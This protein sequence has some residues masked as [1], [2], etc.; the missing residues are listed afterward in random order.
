MSAKRI[1]SALTVAFAKRW[2]LKDQ[3]K[4]K[5]S[6][7]SRLCVEISMYFSEDK[8]NEADLTSLSDYL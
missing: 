8:K 3:P 4:P 5:D 1:A 2:H 7:N 6:I